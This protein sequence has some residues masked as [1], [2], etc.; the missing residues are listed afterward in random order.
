[1]SS[2]KDRL[3]SERGAELIEFALVVPMLLLIILGIADFGFMFQRYEVLTNAAR[4]GARVAVLPGY[5]SA[6]V[7]ARVCAYL[8]SGGVPATGCPNPSNPA[9]SVTDTTVP[10]AVGPA[11]QAKR[12][13]VTYT[14]SYMFIGGVAGLF[15]GTFRTTLPI[16][17]VAIMRSELAAPGP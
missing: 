9:I 10:M 7:K 15:S 5:V 3:R 2:M 16:T 11:L 6:D 1:M 17:T 12:V 4:E 8:A 14:H 13:Q